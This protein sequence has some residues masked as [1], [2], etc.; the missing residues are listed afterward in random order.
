VNESEEGGA[1]DDEP[2]AGD[3]PPSELY[4]QG[5]LLRFSRGGGVGVVRTST[6]RELAFDLRY[7]VVLGGPAE[8]PTAVEL[9]EGM[10]VGYDVGWTSRGL[11]VTKLFPIPAGLER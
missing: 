2:S 10:R 3:A 9:R 6:G 5:M 11:R 1:R 8:N 7:V 4:Y